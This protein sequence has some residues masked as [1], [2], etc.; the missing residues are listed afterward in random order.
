MGT[1]PWFRVLV[2]AGAVL[3]VL[4]LAAGYRYLESRGAFTAVRPGF[5]GT[6]RTVAGAAGDITVA[7][8]VAFVAVAGRTPSEADGLYL[9]AYD[10]PG[11][12]LVR[13]ANV[14]K[15]FRPLALSLYRSADGQSLLALGRRAAGDFS[16]AV[17]DIETVE[18]TVKLTE[19]G[20]ITGD[21]L[22]DPRDLVAVDHDRFYVVNGHAGRTALGRWLDDVF[23]LPRADLLYFD[24][25]KFVTAVEGLSS[26]AGAALSKDGRH[27]YVSESYPR[28]LLAFAR[29]PLTGELKND[30]RL[31]VPSGLEKISP[32]PDGSLWV[33]G[34]PKPLE[35]DRF[36]DDPS[37]PA[38]SQVFR[39]GLDNGEPGSAALIYSN[40]GDEIG[41]AGVAAVAG[42][43]LLIG[44][45]LDGKMLDCALR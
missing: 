31:A 43:H 9:Y 41:A 40:E 37:R 13:L 2:T 22:T 11:A 39:V 23:L 5:S 21:V 36:R 12:R 4:I 42:K 33:A 10:K 35:E 1:G 38:P 27:L 32:A 19:V 25:M 30:G 28:L 16:V 6:C 18:G 7:D 3:A 14:P 45:A 17:F 29:D 26:P 24:G 44:S 15:D 8:G 20:R 34:Q